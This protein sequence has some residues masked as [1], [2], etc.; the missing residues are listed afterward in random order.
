MILSHSDVV[1]MFFKQN[2]NKFFPYLEISNGAR[3]AA[4]NGYIL[5]PLNSYTTQSGGI[6]TLKI[7]Q[8]YYENNYNQINFDLNN[9]I[10]TKNKYWV[11]KIARQLPPKDGTLTPLFESKT[12]YFTFN[13]A[14][15]NSL[16]YDEQGFM[17]IP[18]TYKCT[19][20]T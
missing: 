14:S 17:N 10:S 7:T 9:L 16:G 19:N 2:K 6:L 3:A 5:I 12:Y 4:T 15:V 20:C 8:N 1:T 18:I 13:A 11:F